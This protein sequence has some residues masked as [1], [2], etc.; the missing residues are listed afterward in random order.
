[1]G[2]MGGTPEWMKPVLDQLHVVSAKAREATSGVGEGRGSMWK[3]WLWTSAG[4]QGEWV[5]EDDG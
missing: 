4:G 5:Y 3:R 2:G 1:M